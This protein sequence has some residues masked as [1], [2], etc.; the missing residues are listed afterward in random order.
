MVLFK[1]FLDSGKPFTIKAESFVDLVYIIQNFSMS[2]I[3]QLD[4]IAIK[5]E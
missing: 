4:R 2:F 5:G 1:G 3:K